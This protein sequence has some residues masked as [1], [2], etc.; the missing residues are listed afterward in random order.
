MTA[1][2]RRATLLPVLML[3]TC[4]GLAFHRV[5]GVREVLG[6]TVLCALAPTVVALVSSGAPRPDPAWAHPSK[7]ARETGKPLWPSLV[8]TLLAWTF[9]M[10]ATLY[11]DR[12]AARVLPTPDLI[13]RMSTDLIDAP[14]T[15]LT[16][17]PPAP[18]RPNTLVLVAACVWFAAFTGTELAL[19]TRTLLVPAIPAALALAVPVTLGVGGPGSNTMIVPALIASL[20]LLLLVRAPVTRT[21]V[22]TTAVGVPLVAT[23]VVLT[24]VLGPLLHRANA[25]QP[26]DLHEKVTP[27]PGAPLHAVNPL[28]RVSAWL[29]EPDVALFTVRGKDT[30]PPSGG[31]G[32]WRLAVLDDYDGVSWLPPAGLRPTTGRIPRQSGL[33]PESSTRAVYGVTIQELDGIWLPE[34]DRP[35]R[36]D[37]PGVELLIEPAGGVPATGSGL[38]PGLRYE[39]ESR[40]PHHD[41][42]RLQYLQAADDPGAT[43]LPTPRLGDADDSPTDF[44]REQAMIA[45]RGS[46]FPY[47]QALRL[48]DWLRGTYTYD[49]G[50]VPGHSYRNLRFFLETSRAGTSEQFAAAFA[51]MA[52][53]LNLPSRV[54]VGFTRGDD[55]GDG[56]VQVRSGDVIAWPEIEFA[57]V[58]WV[59]FAPT[60]G[61]TADSPAASPISRAGEPEQAPEQAAPKEAS[62]REKD[63]R[64]AAEPRPPAGHDGPT[65]RAHRPW[66][67]PLWSMAAVLLGTLLVAHVLMAAAAPRLT[68]RRRR[69]RRDPHDRVIGAW[70]QVGDRL[71]H[72]GM[73]ADATRTVSEVVAYGVARL[74]EP[75]GSGLSELGLLV[76]ESVYAGRPVEAADA[77]AAWLRCTAVEAALRHADGLPRRRVRVWRRLRPGGVWAT[78]RARDGRRR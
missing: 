22:R 28:D 39:V 71:V 53:T 69:G 4:V 37:A 18:A 2:R 63:A 58:G 78:L 76:N 30:E 61:P 41:P 49:R 64:I 47:Q 15:I 13:R 55:R 7:P 44:F 5:L 6:V 68:R 8:A 72:A 35:V 54:V 23:I 21:S 27:P 57:D 16:T 19:R 46:T 65:S 67:P 32:C 66:R 51:V 1:A 74:P 70:E 36:V 12:A 60:P 20:G 9:A 43:S 77:D 73:S 48:A 52:R 11:R 50:A 38:R 45:T 62:R 33:A 14:R 34:A 24:G 75:G 3:A 10:S 29:Q 25:R 40:I 26:P 31:E 17:V 42:D 59:P 56:S